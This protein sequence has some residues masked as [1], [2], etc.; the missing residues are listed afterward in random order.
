VKAY[1]AL[2]LVGDSPEREHMRRARDAILARGG[3][4]GSNVF[5]RFL[6]RAL[7]RA[8]VGGRSDRAGRNHAVAPWFPFHLS[9]VSYWSRT[10]LVPLLVLAAVKPRARNPRG[11][12]IDELCTRRRPRALRW[13]RANHQSPVWFGI[14]A[15]LDEAL[16]VVVPLFPRRLRERA[17]AKAVAFVTE[18]LNGENGVGAIFPRW[19]TP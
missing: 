9:R 7:R 4:G 12:R 16:R 3:A 19:P 14:F 10:V 6:L 13:V 1:L 2:K 8:A 11:V 17:I 15:A 5:T 18:R